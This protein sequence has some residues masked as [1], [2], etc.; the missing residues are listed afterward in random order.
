MG[1]VNDERI[2]RET[3]IFVP[4]HLLPFPSLRM[5]NRMA[6]RIKTITPGKSLCQEELKC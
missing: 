3:G 5:K 2:P 6:E 1:E 4:S